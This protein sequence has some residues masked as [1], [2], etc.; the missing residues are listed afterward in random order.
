MWYEDSE[1]EANVEA[2][3]QEPVAKRTF[4]EKSAKLYSEVEKEL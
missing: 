1:G 3:V 2:T 4:R